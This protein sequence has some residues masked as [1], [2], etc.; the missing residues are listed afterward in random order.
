MTAADSAAS[1]QCAVPLRTTPG[2][3]RSVSPFFSWLYGRSFSQSWTAAG[4][5]QP[6]DHAALCRRERQRWRL[7]RVSARERAS[8]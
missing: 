8:L 3:T 2:K 6:S 1:R 7:D 4:V 5:S